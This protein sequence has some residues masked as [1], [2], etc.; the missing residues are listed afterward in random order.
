MVSK[1]NPRHY[2]KTYHLNSHAS[3]QQTSSDHLTSTRFEDN[4]VIF[5]I[6]V[7]VDQQSNHFNCSEDVCSHK[8]PS[9]AEGSRVGRNKSSIECRDDDQ[10]GYVG[11]LEVS[12]EEPMEQEEDV[13][14]MWRQ[15][16]NTH[17]LSVSTFHLVPQEPII[18][19]SRK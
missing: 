1:H 9:N 11:W 3:H 17:G 5:L 14:P 19:H 7:K 10:D 6:R 16:R 12:F 13:K 8:G 2:S 15:A 18:F 4:A